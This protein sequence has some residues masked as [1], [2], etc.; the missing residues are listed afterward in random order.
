[1]NCPNCG[2]IINNGEAF[3]GSCGYSLS[4]PNNGMNQNNMQQPT[5]N[6]FQQPMNNN[7]QQ[8]ANNNF[9]QPMYNVGAQNRNNSKAMSSFYLAL[10]GLLITFLCIPAIILGNKAKDEIAQTGEGGLGF[11]K[12]GTIIG[13]I[14]LALWIL[15]IIGSVTGAISS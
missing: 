1:M 7:F 11:A 4:Q 6:N 2:N 14:E 9:Q 15:Y 13:Y 5:N 12:A 8:P 10:G 3:C